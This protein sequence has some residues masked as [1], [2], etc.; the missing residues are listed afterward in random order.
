[1]FVDAFTE[2]ALKLEKLQ[3]GWI[4]EDRELLEKCDK[5]NNIALNLRVINKVYA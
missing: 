3:L 1:M 5:S 2:D 4:A